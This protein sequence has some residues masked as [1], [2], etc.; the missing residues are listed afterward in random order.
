MIRDHFIFHPAAIEIAPLSPELR[1]G[2]YVK[3]P[4]YALSRLRRGL[5]LAVQRL[6][7]KGLDHYGIL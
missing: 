3:R 1:E 4:S 7:A 6:A 5:Y 2:I